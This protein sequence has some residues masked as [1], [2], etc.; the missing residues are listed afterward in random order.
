MTKKESLDFLNRCIKSIEN[1]SEK[2]INRFKELYKKH[3][4]SSDEK[5]EYIHAPTNNNQKNFYGV[6]GR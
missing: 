3:C 2:E 5:R 6:N 1:I 4:T